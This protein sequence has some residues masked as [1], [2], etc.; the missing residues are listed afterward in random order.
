MPNDAHRENY[1]ARCDLRT[2]QLRL[3][4]HSICLHLKEK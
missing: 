1:F 4:L 2:G 3:C